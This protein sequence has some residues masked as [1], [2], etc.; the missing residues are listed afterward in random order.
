[1]TRFTT[2]LPLLVALATAVSCTSEKYATPLTKGGSPTKA[3][4]EAEAADPSAPTKGAATK[5]VSKG[6]A[7]VKEDPGATKA[8]GT[9]KTVPARTRPPLSAED[10]KSAKIQWVVCATCHGNTGKGDGLAGLALN[11]KPRTFADPEWQTST[12]DDRIFKVI[13]EGG[14]AVGLSPLMV[15]YPHLSD[16]TIYA[17]V[18]KIRNFARTK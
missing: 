6:T 10:R 4:V 1:M 3:K 13:K 11:P 7:Q 18:D 8:P 17:L 5:P 16:G 14:A 15:A 12:S 9:Q 2:L